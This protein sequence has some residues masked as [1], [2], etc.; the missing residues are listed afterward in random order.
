M[1]NYG[2]W[3]NKRWEAA[4]GERTGGKRLCE[5]MGLRRTLKIFI[6]YYLLK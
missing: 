5:R 6:Q 4:V 1:F 2:E 3:D